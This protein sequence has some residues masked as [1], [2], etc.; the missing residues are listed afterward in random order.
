MFLLIFVTL[1][2]AGYRH[3][4]SD[5]TDI[6]LPS[7]SGAPQIHTYALIAPKRSLFRSFSVRKASFF[8]IHCLLHLQ[9]ETLRFIETCLFDYNL[10]K[11]SM[12]SRMIVLYILYTPQARQNDIWLGQQW[13]D[14]YSIHI[15]TSIYWHKS[16]NSTH[17]QEEDCT[18]WQNNHISHILGF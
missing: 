15:I 10:C 18:K 2:S 12:R 1:S 6:L 3:S 16:A 9:G 8:P 17:Q 13:R 11:G 14:L 5:R 7:F 4:L